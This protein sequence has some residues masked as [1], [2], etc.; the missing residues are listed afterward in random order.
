M[1]NKSEHY[2]VVHC[3]VHWKSKSHPEFLCGKNGSINLELVKSLF[4]ESEEERT[5]EE[6]K[7]T[8]SVE[9]G[10]EGGRERLENTQQQSNCRN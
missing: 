5:R 4:S 1:L 9:R 7:E 2:S 3:V 10:R 8:G 6:E